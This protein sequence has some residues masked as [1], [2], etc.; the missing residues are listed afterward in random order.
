M[1]LKG[2]ITKSNYIDYDKAL[3]KGIQLI[4]SVD[5]EFGF[6]IITSINVGLRIGDILKLKHQ[7]FKN[8]YVLLRE[9]KTNKAKKVPFNATILKYYE[10][11]LKRIPKHRKSDF[12]FIS[13]KESVYSRQ[14][15]NRKLKQVFKFK[16]KN[17]SSHSLRKCFGR[18]VY[19]VNNESEKALI[20]LNEIY[21][22]SS[23]A[24]TRAYLDITQ[25]E[26]NDV[27]MSL[28]L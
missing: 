24:Q 20:M 10:L 16:D 8:G 3:N 4:N 13:Q 19:E 1:S 2:S 9:Q 22:H 21:N 5:A 26:I 25:E 27:Y 7:D 15:I 18:R 12:V 23:L 6:Y 11:L 14:Q 17:I 28:D